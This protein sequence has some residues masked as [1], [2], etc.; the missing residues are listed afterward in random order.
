VFDKTP[1]IIADFAP[2]ASEE[3]ASAKGGAIQAV[4]YKAAQN[5]LSGGDNDEYYRI[6]SLSPGQLAQEASTGK[7]R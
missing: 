5:A 6:R 1:P 7:F 3:G 4:Q 2:L